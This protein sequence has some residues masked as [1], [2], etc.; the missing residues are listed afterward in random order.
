MR[1]HYLQHV[2]FEDPGI[3]L[4]WAQN[5]GHQMAS[6]RFY[7]EG[8]LPN[9]KDYEGLIIMGGPMSIHDDGIYPWIADEKR[10]IRE[11]IDKGK[12]ILGI[13][14]GAQFLADAL[15]G[16]VYR[17][18]DKEI[19]FFPVRTVRGRSG[20]SGLFPDNFLPFHWH[21]ET[22]SIPRGAMRLAFSSGCMNQAFEAH[23]G[24]ILAFQFHLEVSVKNIQKLYRH[25]ADE[26]SIGTYV[27]NSRQAMEH[28]HGLGESHE[29]MYQILDHLFPKESDHGR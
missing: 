19:G 20:I 25:C 1:L 3:I 15:G 5:R 29:L 27:Q 16:A 17:N 4:P 18:P 13:C 8:E 10:F 24:Q 28:L 26:I 22:F 11:A 23:S 12:I 21:G 9:H 14:L 6:T 2:S 7:D